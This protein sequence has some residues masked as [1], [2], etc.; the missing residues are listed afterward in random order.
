MHRATLPSL[1][2][3]AAAFLCAVPA[4]AQKQAT[5]SDYRQ[6]AWLQSEPWQQFLARQGG[7]WRVEW[8][9]ATSTPKAIWGSGLALDGWRENSLE[10]ARQHANR[11]LLDQR[12]L[13]GLGASG[14]RE[15][16]G[17]RMGQ[18]WTFTYQ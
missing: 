16:I 4:I 3:P 14:F 18:T 5:E 15:V 6:S 11:V 9:P 12:E 10:A 17:S 1:L 13:L 2:V 7:S 8:N